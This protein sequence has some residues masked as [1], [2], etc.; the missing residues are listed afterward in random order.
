MKTIQGI[1]V[2]VLATLLN[3][4]YSL[5]AVVVHLEFIGRDLSKL[6]IG[7]LFCFYGL[8]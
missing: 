5:I 6:L 4:S 3:I 1:G 8:A 2:A 7:L